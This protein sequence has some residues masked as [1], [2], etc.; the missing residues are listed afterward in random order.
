MKNKYSVVRFAPV[1]SSRPLRK[2]PVEDWD[3]QKATNLVDLKLYK[4][5]WFENIES[6]IEEE[7]RKF[8]VQKTVIKRSGVY[9]IDAFV[10][11]VEDIRVKDKDLADNLESRGIKEIAYG[12]SQ[13]WSE[14][15]T[16]KDSIVELK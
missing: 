13:N 12:I 8:T 14:E 5:F 9:F 2:F 10:E 1:D 16:D 15:F 4:C 3:V 11:T 7:P 6:D